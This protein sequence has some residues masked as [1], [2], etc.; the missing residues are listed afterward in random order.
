MEKLHRDIKSM[1]DHV[2]VPTEKLNETVQTALLSG[3]KKRKLHIFQRPNLMAS[4]A[5][6]FILAIGGIL[7][8]SFYLGPSEKEVH[9]SGNEGISYTESIF[10]HVSD[11]GLKRMAMEGMT[12]NLALES[13][14]Q[15]LKVILE[16][17]YLDSQRM[18]ISYRLDRTGS[19]EVIEETSISLDLYV[20]GKSMGNH[21][22]N[23]M[24][25]NQLVETGDVFQF[26]TSEEFPEHP[27]IEIRIKSINNIEGD[28]SFTFDI[29]KKEEFIKKSSLASK[30]DHKGNYFSVGQARLTPSILVLNTGTKLKLEKKYSD[31]SHYEISITALGADGTVYLDHYSR[32]GG[33]DS[34]DLKA[35]ELMINEKVEIP[36]K[37]NSYLYKLVPYIATYNG[38]KVGDN[39]YIWN[40]IS[41][42]YNQG[43]ILET[44]SKIK[45]FE[46][47]EEPNET[48]VYYEMDT[49]LPIFPIIIDRNNNLEYQAISYKQKDSL[50][51]VTYPKVKDP[52]SSQFL[53]YDASYEVFSDLE[54]EIDLK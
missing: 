14:D 43:V 50:L 32:R 17:G 12:K 49:L 45:V 15:G 41:A 28:W 19:M 5:S 2:S 3:K 39:G 54:V 26:E 33:N 23:G 52:A 22:F 36:R 1:V 9:F 16:E 27:E 40:E 47:K 51:E 38:E 25:T 29:E 48:I 18:A 11:A 20:N 53:M 6:L 31:L 7:F 21:G 4:V 24:K 44:D 35:P 10:Y 34:Y 30:E 46:I 37:S 8:S 13:E 42:P